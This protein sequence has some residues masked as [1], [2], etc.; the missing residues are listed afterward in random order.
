MK[1]SSSDSLFIAELTSGFMNSKTLRCTARRLSVLL[2]I[3]MRVNDQISLLL[4]KTNPLAPSRITVTGMITVSS[5]QT[6]S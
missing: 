4:L 3:T 5:D 2:A 1:V 6:Y